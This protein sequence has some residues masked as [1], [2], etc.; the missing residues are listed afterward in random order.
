VS[1]YW[2]LP[3]D[4]HLRYKRPGDYVDHFKAILRTAVDDRLRTNRVAVEM[5]GGLDSTSIAA[6]AKEMLAR[7]RGQ[8]DLQAFTFVYDRL[9]PDRERQVSGLPAEALGIAINNLAADDYP[10]FESTVRG[11]RVVPVRFPR[12]FI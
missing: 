2:S 6:T 1:S 3:T 7:R 11:D 10:L 5:S 12:F 4:G 8:F 9:I